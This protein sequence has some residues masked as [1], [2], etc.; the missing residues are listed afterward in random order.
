[1]LSNFD[2]HQ[3]NTLEINLPSGTVHL[4][5]WEYLNTSK[6]Y[7]DAKNPKCFFIVALYKKLKPDYAFDVLMAYS[8]Q[9]IDSRIS[10]LKTHFESRIDK[11]ENLR[12]DYRKR[13]KN[14]ELVAA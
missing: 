1:M 7:Q 3:T 8:I 6:I 11:L 2:N 10:E 9:K 14:R 4:N 5:K 12:E 13:I